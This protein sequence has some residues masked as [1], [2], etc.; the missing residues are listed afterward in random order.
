M[1]RGGDLA[2]DVRDRLI[3]LRRPWLCDAIRLTKQWLVS[4]IFIMKY[5]LAVLEQAARFEPCK[6]TQGVPGRYSIR[7][8]HCTPYTKP[9][10]EQP[11]AVKTVE[12]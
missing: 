12:I 9:S 6:Q 8:Q 10:P 7:Y 5:W 2:L 1:P 4:A 11:V 3:P